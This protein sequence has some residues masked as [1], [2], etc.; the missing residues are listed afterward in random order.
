MTRKNKNSRQK[1]FFF[2]DYIESEIIDN[3]NSKTVKIS[4]NRITFLFFIF[5]SLIIIFS[6]KIIYLSL[7]S[8]K[9]YFSLN[10]D[11]SF[12]ISS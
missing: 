9:K 5:F 3:N 10:N 2:E 1:S 6:F 7:F 12:Y 11:S 4:L 8:E